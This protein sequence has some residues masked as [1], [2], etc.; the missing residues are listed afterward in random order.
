MA[1]QPTMFEL[2]DALQLKNPEFYHSLPPDQQKAFHPYIVMKWLASSTNDDQLLLVN[3]IANSK[4]FALSHSHKDLMMDVLAACTSGS[5]TRY[6]W[7]KRP[8][9]ASDKRHQV[10]IDYYGPQ[11]DIDEA[12]RT[13]TD[14]Q[15]IELCHQLGMQD[16]E[17]KALLKQ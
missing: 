6:K 16:E 7:P 2:L 8:S 15:I 11:V 9:R 4:V 10:F 1:K 13:H 12:M 14:E 3:D 5:R 17:V